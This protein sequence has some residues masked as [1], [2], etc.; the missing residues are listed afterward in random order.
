M[1][2]RHSGEI[3]TEKLRELIIHPE[4]KAQL[5]TDD[6]QRLQQEW[7][8]LTE[9]KPKPEPESES[10]QIGTLR[11][12]QDNSIVEVP[13]NYYDQYLLDTLDRL[14][15]PASAGN[16]EFLKSARLIGEV[17]GYC[18]QYIGDSYFEYRLRELIYSGILE[19]QGIPAG[20]RFFSVRRKHR[21]HAKNTPQNG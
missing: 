16:A 2:Y 19:I 9:P 15:P 3:P 8:S 14:R 21:S 6:I 7:Q 17:I 1:H 5:S 20:M 10:A 4:E 18:D 11:I 13:A 12:W